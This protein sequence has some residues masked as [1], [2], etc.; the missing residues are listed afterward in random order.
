MVQSEL[1]VLF[2][3]GLLAIIRVLEKMLSGGRTNSLP[4]SICFFDRFAICPVNNEA[5]FLLLAPSSS[6]LSGFSGMDEQVC[7]GCQRDG[8]ASSF[9]R[10]RQ[11]VSL[12]AT[13]S[14]LLASTAWLRGLCKHC[15]PSDIQKTSHPRSQPHR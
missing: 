9:A 14:I 1:Q 5:V 10:R 2:L 13:L 12:R 7:T 3:L 8:S 11:T 15:Q 6:E 4:S